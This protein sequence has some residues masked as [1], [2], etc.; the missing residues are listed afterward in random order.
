MYNSREEA[1]QATYCV[2][3]KFAEMAG[4]QLEMLYKSR[5]MDRMLHRTSATQ[6]FRTQNFQLQCISK[7]T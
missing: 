7:L 5:T 1:A 3:E 4:L 6:N 2:V